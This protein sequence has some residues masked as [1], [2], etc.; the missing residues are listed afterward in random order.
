VYFFSV[1]KK[2][3]E[4]ASSGIPTFPIWVKM[5]VA[6]RLFLTLLKYSQFFLWLAFRGH[7]KTR[8]EWQ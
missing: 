6:G 4:E 5:N 1:R 2:K 8:F 3:E 7:E